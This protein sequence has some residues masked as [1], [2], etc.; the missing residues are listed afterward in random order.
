M[1]YFSKLIKDNFPLNINILRKDRK[2]KQKKVNGS[3]I[4]PEKKNN[5]F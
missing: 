1:N 2:K 4:K 3:K 5:K